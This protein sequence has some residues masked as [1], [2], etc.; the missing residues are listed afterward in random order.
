[1]EERLGLEMGNDEAAHKPRRKYL[2]SEMQGA[3]RQRTWE[4]E[5]QLHSS[6]SFS[7]KVVSKYLVTASPISQL[8][9]P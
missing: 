1:M 9:V 7:G 4:P 3:Y 2:P 6:T 5:D 8:L